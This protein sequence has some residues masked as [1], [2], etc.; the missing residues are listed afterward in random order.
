MSTITIVG[1][2]ERVGTNHIT[3]VRTGTVSGIRS[4]ITG[5]SGPRADYQWHVGNT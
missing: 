2:H 3:H 5:S 1:A 4:A